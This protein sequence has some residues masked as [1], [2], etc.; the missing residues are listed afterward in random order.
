MKYQGI[1]IAFVVFLLAACG[2]PQGT[3]PATATNGED[4]K[5]IRE[6]PLLVEWNTPF[7]TPPFDLI[8]SGDYLAALRDFRRARRQA[9]G[10]SSCIPP[11]CT[12]RSTS[13]AATHSINSSCA[14]SATRR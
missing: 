12:C 8:E 3:E 14:G 6:N 7:G 1:A 4:V 2:G 10:R 5:E 11:S 13:P 9:A